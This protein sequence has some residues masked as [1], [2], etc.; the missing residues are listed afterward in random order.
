MATNLNRQIRRQLDERISALSET[1]QRP[2]NGWIRTVRQAL[3]MSSKDLAERMGVHSSRVPRIES[4]ETKDSVTLSS[5]ERAAQAMDCRL[6]YQFVP[7][8]SFEEIVR[9][10]ARELARHRVSKTSRTM[11]LEDQRVDPD[12]LSDIERDLVDEYLIDPPR[13]FWS[14]KI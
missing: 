1:P 9:R 5:L 14:R 3:G 7:N 4:D 11:A 6:V 13:D 8:G 12:V 10:R 2:E